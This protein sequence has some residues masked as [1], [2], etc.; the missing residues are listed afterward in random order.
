MI[1]AEELEAEVEF[2]EQGLLPAVLQDSETGEVLMVAYMNRTALNKTLDTGKAHFWSRSRQKLWLKGET[3]GN[4]QYIQEIRLDCDGDT[5]LLKVKPAGPACHTGHKSCFYRRVEG[6]CLPEEGGGLSL[7]FLW[8]LS[9][10]I[11][12]RRQQ[13]PEDSYTS[14]LYREGLDKICKKIGEEASEVIVGAKNDVNR[15]VIYESADLIYHLLVLLR[16]KNISLG[17]IVEEL[18]SR[19]G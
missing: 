9:Q 3:S 7:N 2:D 6:E 17:D 8:T 16:L 4:F 11:D 13:M 10:I 19:H 14:Y 15:E 12:D 1:K 5:L 18:S